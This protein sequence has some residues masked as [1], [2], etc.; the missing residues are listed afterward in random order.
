MQKPG[1]NHQRQFWEQMVLNSC[2]ISG[3]L[4]ASILTIIVHVSG[5][6]NQISAHKLVTY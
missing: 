2:V 5:V 3:R 6:K 4:L 1:A